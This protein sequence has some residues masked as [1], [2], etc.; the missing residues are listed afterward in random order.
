MYLYNILI[1]PPPNEPLQIHSYTR[2]FYIIREASLL[3]LLRGSQD[4]HHT[5]QHATRAAPLLVLG[6][7][8]AKVI[9]SPCQPLLEGRGQRRKPLEK[10]RD[11]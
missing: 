5:L 10:H 11:G 3:F 4:L 1:P 7:T 9:Q 8:G 2:T 6:A